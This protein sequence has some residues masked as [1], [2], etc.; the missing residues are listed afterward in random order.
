M[1]IKKKFG[2]KLIHF[3]LSV[4]TKNQL[5]RLCRNLGILINPDR[6]IRWNQISMK[7]Q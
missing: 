1:Q 6:I 2:W 4:F 3:V 5:Y 7:V